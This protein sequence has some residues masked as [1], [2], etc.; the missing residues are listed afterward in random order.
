[1][2][3][4][5]FI[6]FFLFIKLI[7]HCLKGPFLQANEEKWADSAI[8]R[9]ILSVHKHFRQI[10]ASGR[11]AKR[12]KFLFAPSSSDWANRQKLLTSLSVPKH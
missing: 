9:T 1:M 6:T 10:R 11:G 4:I 3:K 5:Y 8:I 2:L 12:I 7:R